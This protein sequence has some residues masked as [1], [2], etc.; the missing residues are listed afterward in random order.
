MKKIALIEKSNN[1]NF[2]NRIEDFQAYIGLKKLDYECKLVTILDL[3]QK[4][5]LIKDISMACGCLNFMRYIF[6]YLIKD[7]QKLNSLEYFFNYIYDYKHDY[8]KNNTVK[9]NITISEA[10]N[11]IKTTEKSYFVKP[12]K[13]K[14]F[15]PTIISNV[16]TKNDISIN[17]LVVQEI[18]TFIMF[19]APYFNGNE[20]L[21][22]NEKCRIQEVKEY[23][24]EY[25]LY[26]DNKY[27]ISQIKG[28]TYYKG[29]IEITI[30]ENRF[31]DIKN[32][33]S[34][35]KDK[36]PRSYSLDIGLNYDFWLN[37]YKLNLIEFTDFYSIGNYGLDSDI[38]TELLI[39]R[40]NEIIGK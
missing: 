26:I 31:L 18:E 32:F 22:L 24:S 38:Y 4:P 27:A 14:A 17:D 9:N 6:S 5:E 40:F 33:I 28:I 10:I 25:R 2:P 12:I 34:S 36:M 7:R 35:I 15:Y 39:N 13:A 3:T 20:E 21:L 23:E 16:K 37:T 8:L 30:P 11:F 19:N 1:D 29:N